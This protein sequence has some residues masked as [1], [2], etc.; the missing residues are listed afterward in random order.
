LSGGAA[1][2]SWDLWAL[3]VVAYEML[4]G[5]YPF[6]EAARRQPFQVDSMIPPRVRMPA[7]P[8]T[9]DAFFRRALAPDATLRP[10]SALQFAAEFQALAP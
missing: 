9:W 2:E 7:A 8:E 5:A 1:A 6:S 3:A 10:S 4:T